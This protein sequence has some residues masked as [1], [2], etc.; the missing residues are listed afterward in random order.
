MS[1]LNQGAPLSIPDDQLAAGALE[2]GAIATEVDPAALLAAMTA[3]QARVAALEGEKAE[4]NAEPVIA[5]AQALAADLAD[6][7]SGKTLGYQNPD[8]HA[9]LLALA[10]DA[11]AAARETVQSGDGSALA[12]IA[13]RIERALSKITLPGD[14]HYLRQA[15]SHAADLHDSADALT[16][17]RRPAKALEGSVIG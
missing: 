7:A 14:H 13:S 4:R 11:I 3:M 6:H 17:A 8:Q 1:E 10:D 5:T 2:A 16:A 9:P 12:Q 15:Q